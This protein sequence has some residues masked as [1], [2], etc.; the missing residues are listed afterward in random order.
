M[1]KSI[2]PTY[3]NDAKIIC[4]CGNSL[5]VG[6]TVKQAHVE[7]CSSCH[8]FFTGKEKII[9]TAGKVER[10]KA[11]EEKSRKLKE[12]RIRSRSTVKKRT[13]KLKQ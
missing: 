5:T 4:S 2:H 10:F 12:E 13:A 7:I 9:D 11:R 1:K 6:S 8:P 3:Y